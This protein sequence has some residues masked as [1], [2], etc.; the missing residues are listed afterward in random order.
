[1]SLT[2]RLENDR[3]RPTES[4]EPIK[5]IVFSC[6]TV[7]QLETCKQWAKYIY[8]SNPSALHLVGE[9][10]HERQKQLDITYS[11]VHIMD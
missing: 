7:Q 5:R 10:I 9:Y 2:N 3:K 1:M 4:L 6:N 11:K 8:K